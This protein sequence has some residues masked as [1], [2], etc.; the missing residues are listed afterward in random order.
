MALEIFDIVTFKHSRLFQDFKWQIFLDK[1]VSQMFCNILVT[2][3]TIRQ[4]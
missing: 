2:W 4:Y 1:K 3:G